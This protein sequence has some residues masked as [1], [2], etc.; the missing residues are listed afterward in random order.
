MQ[1]PL[2]WIDDPQP[3]KMTMLAF[4]SVKSGLSQTRMKDDNTSKI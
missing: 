2:A 4:L 3:H 1:T